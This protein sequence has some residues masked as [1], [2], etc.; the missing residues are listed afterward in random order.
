MKKYSLLIMSFLLLLVSFIAAWY[1]D[2]L[3]NHL[4]IFA[5]PIYTVLFICFVVLL[6]MS[7]RRII[8]ERDYSGCFSILILALLVVLIAF[9]PFRDARVKYELNRF[10]ADRLEIIRMIQTDQLRPKDEIGNVV[11]PAGYRRLS[12]DGEVFVYQNDENGQVIG[13]WVFRGMLSG[14]AEL[15]YSSGG[16]EPIRANESGHPIRKIVRLKENWYYVETDY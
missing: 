4:F 11:L 2:H 12:S 14:S 10:E 13:F 15:I 1:E 16:E 6:V 3:F 9:F 7:I 8:K 5:L